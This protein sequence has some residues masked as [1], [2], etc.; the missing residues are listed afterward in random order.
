MEVFLTGNDCCASHKTVLVVG[1]GNFSFACEFVKCLRNTDWK[2]YATSFDSQDKVFNDEFAK[3]NVKDLESNSHVTVNHDVDATQLH[4][5]YPGLVCSLIIF[6]FPHVGGKSNI[7]KCRALLCNFFSSATKHLC[8]H[9]R[10]LV[11]LCSGQ[12]GTPADVSRGSYGN[13]WQ[14]AS[15]AAKAGK[16]PCQI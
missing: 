16:P 6:N 14:V 1:E 2:I 5:T 7:K 9:G 15:Q 13:S 10:I 3:Q 4:E 12:G 8:E 11:S